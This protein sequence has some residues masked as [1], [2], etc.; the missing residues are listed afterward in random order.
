[1][2]GPVK[3]YE[4]RNAIAETLRDA[5]RAYEIPEACVSY[6]L[7]PGT[8]SDAFASKRWYVLSRIEKHNRAQLVA[9]A[10]RVLDDH[11]SSQLEDLIKRSGAQGASGDFRNLIFS[12]DGPKPE[13]VLTDAL[14]N[15]VKITKNEQFC[16]VYDR[17]IESQGLTWAK[18][19]NWWQGVTR[20]EDSMMAGRHLYQRL[21][22]SLASDPERV[23]FNR[24]CG[25]YANPEG[26]DWPALIPQ[27]YMH[28]DPYT[29][30]SRSN[31]GPLIRQRMDFLLL[32]PGEIRIVI[33]IDGSHHYSSGEKPDPRRYAEMVSEDRKLRLAG[34]DVYRFGGYEFVDENGGTAVDEFIDAFCARYELPAIDRSR[35]PA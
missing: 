32:L 23:F 30:A 24:Y 4:L 13:I 2:P 5:L 14:N 11:A 16:L 9:L 3:L 21:S 33:E 20:I 12:A 10:R 1:M 27:V 6:G 25:A 18:L 31:P 7:E 29:K 19:V 34:Y 15:V 17:P 22:R 8:E 26:W 35:W 28:Y